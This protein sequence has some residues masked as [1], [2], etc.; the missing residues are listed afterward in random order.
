MKYNKQVKSKQ[1]E[2]TGSNLNGIY[3]I[4]SI[5]LGIQF[6]GFGA[7]FR[8]IHFLTDNHV[9]KHEICYMSPFL[10]SA[11][12]NH[13]QRRPYALFPEPIRLISPEACEAALKEA[14][15]NLLVRTLA[16]RMFAKSITVQLSVSMVNRGQAYSPK[17]IHSFYRNLE[18]LIS[19]RPDNQA[20]MLAEYQLGTRSRGR[21]I[22]EPA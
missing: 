14:V 11:N 15:Y 20:W 7:L 3:K 16:T 21:P 22:K 9:G 8:S 18:N 2:P 13:K 6:K 17:D 10:K 12:L 19:G 1:L 4:N 5:R